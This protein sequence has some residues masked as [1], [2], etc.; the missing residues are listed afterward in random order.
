MIGEGITRIES[1]SSFTRDYMKS[2]QLPSTLESIDERAFD[3]CRRLE[4]IEIP[5]GVKEIGKTAFEDCIGLK[6]VINN[7]SQTV[8][9]PEDTLYPKRVAPYDYF[10]DGERVTTV[11]P[12]KTAVGK[13]RKFPVA[14]ECDSGTMS[15]ADEQKDIYYQYREPLKLPN[16]KKKGYVFCGWT[17]KPVSNYAWHTI[18]NEDRDNYYV[19]TANWAGTIKLYAQ[20]VKMSMNKQGKRK[21]KVTISKWRDARQLKIQYATNKKYKNAKKIIVKDDEL[22][23][24]RKY[25]KKSNKKKHYV[26]EYK[27]KKRMLSVTLNKL[28]ANKKYYFRFQFS[29]NEY[30]PLTDDY[31]Y[32]ISDWFKKSVKM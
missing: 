24:I 12:G 11:P 4:S 5:S 1:I 21:L 29:G 15:K 25:G 31:E 28:K 14:L 13:A 23:N 6:T 7:S 20:F 26:L 30:I 18:T 22:A 9:L 8:Y 3:G 19:S 27:K 16:L 2:I 17:A 32:E 10:I